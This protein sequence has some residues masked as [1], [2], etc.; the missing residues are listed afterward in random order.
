VQVTV[1]LLADSD[2]YVEANMPEWLQWARFAFRIAYMVVMQLFFKL[3]TQVRPH[4]GA[5]R[6]V[7]GPCSFPSLF[8]CC[9]CSVAHAAH[10]RSAFRRRATAMPASAFRPRSVGCGVTRGKFG[11]GWAKKGVPRATFKLRACVCVLPALTCFARRRIA[12][13]W[14]TV[15]A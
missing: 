10:P 4:P 1:Q 7:G 15:P 12:L 9:R 5:L 13:G 11:R 8:A 3:M 6:A 2:G 14:G